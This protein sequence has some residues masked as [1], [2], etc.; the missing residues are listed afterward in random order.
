MN[1]RSFDQNKGQ[2]GSF[3]N[4][5]TAGTALAADTKN[6]GGEKDLRTS[7]QS[8]ALAVPICQPERLT[9]LDLVMTFQSLAGN[10]SRLLHPLQTAG[11]M[12]S[13]AAET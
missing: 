13:I 11:D 1:G 7:E 12:P 3:T 8:P 6:P 10:F 4:C 5:P 9:R 2:A